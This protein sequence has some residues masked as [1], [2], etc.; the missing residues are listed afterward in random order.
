MSKVNQNLFLVHLLYFLVMT[1]TDY[2]IIVLFSILIL[3]IGLSFSKTQSGDMKSFF[4]AGGAVPWWISSLSLF[5]GFLS[6]GTFV[7]WGSIAYSSGFVSVSIQWTMSIAGF[8]VGF[9]IAP[10]WNKTHCLTAAEFISYRL[11][12][13]IQKT[14]SYIYLVIMVFM[15]GVYLYSISRILEVSTGFSL[16]PIIS[17]LGVIVI[18]Y[19]T[20][21][22]LWAV[23]V[24]DT[25]QFVILSTAALIVVPLS[26]E[27][28][29]GIQNFMQLIPVEGFF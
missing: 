16:Y 4:S 22:G 11:G 5:M 1:I 27:K 25:L 2:V 15:T 12:I 17:I 9:L 7:V 3:S 28:V 23:V 14:Y 24:T 6:S 21:G 10:K 8:L 26:L 19:T 20:L 29:G 18:L 13:R